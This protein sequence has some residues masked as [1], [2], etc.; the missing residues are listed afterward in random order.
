MGFANS[1]RLAPSLTLSYFFGLNDPSFGGITQLLWLRYIC[2]WSF[3]KWFCEV[4]STLSLSL[5]NSSSLFLRGFPDEFA[6]SILL[7]LSCSSLT[8]LLGL[9]LTYPSFRQSFSIVFIFHQFLAIDL[10]SGFFSL[11]DWLFISLNSRISI[12]RSGI[13]EIKLGSSNLLTP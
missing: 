4:L 9:C 12:G 2:G 10:I 7:A 11:I 13:L 1:T 6:N 8:L 5:S 3:G